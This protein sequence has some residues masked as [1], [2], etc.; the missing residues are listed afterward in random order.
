MGRG[1]PGPK[2]L[3]VAASASL[4][5]REVFEA[6]GI[7]DRCPGGWEGDLLG[8][9]RPDGSHQEHQDGESSDG[10][11]S[12]R[13]DPD[14]GEPPGEEASLGGPETSGRGEPAAAGGFGKVQG[15]LGDGCSGFSGN[16]PIVLRSFG[17]AAEE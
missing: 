10:P 13:R 6:D 15:H 8:L 4:G 12:S 14:P 9:E 5:T 16:P 3:L 7:P 11:G 1:L 17:A 2:L